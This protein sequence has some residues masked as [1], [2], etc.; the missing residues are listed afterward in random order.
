[1]KKAILILFCT[2]I[3]AFNGHALNKLDEILPVRGICM[4][5]PIPEGVDR[6]L[7]FIRNELVPRKVNTIVLRIDYR[8]QYESHPELIDENALSVV[9][10]GRE[11]AAGIPPV[12]RDAGDFCGTGS[13]QGN[14]MAESMGIVLFELLSAA[15]RCPWRGLRRHRRNRRGV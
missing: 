12:Q 9:W 15:S 2:S 5:A 4:S 14:Q 7:D 11:V 6:F 8:Y 13:G 3:L 10:K 1:M